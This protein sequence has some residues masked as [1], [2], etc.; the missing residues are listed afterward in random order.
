MWE[1][2]IKPVERGVLVQLVDQSGLTSTEARVAYRRWASVKGARRTG[3][4]RTFKRALQRAIARAEARAD[5]LNGHRP[6]SARIAEIER[7]DPADPLRG[8]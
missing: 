4:S 3:R 5:E 7:V 8:L 2:I 6:T 1:V